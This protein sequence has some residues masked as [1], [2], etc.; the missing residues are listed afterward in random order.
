MNKRPFQFIKRFLKIYWHQYGWDVFGFSKMILSN[1][2][3]MF[4][5]INLPFSNSLWS[6]SIKLGRQVFI[7]S[8]TSFAIIL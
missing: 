4:C 5:P 6:R 8:A 2:V 1:T 7:L 3:L